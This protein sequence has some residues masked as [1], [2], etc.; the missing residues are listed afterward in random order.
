LGVTGC[1]RCPAGEK[2]TYRHTNE[3]DGKMLR[4]CWTNGVFELPL[5]A[6]LHDG[7][8]TPNRTMGWT[9]RP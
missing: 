5:K 1:Y 4:R 7:S 9:M 6:R 3:E 8:S 2:L